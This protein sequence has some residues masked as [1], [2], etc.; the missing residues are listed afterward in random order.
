MEA[1]KYKN[2]IIDMFMQKGD[3]DEL[4]EEYAAE[5]VEKYKLDF[6]DRDTVKA[7]TRAEIRSILR[8]AGLI[9]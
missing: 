4:T 9:E 3:L 1:G 2:T 8:D 6:L 7:I 5:A